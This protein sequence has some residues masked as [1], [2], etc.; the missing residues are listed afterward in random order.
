MMERIKYPKWRFIGYTK[1]TNTLL[2]ND[3]LFN[4]ASNIVKNYDINYFKTYSWGGGPNWKLRVLKKAMNIVGISEDNLSL[5][6]Q[7]GIYFAPLAENWKEI[8]NSRTRI[9]AKKKLKTSEEIWKDFS[10]KVQDRALRKTE[11][12]KFDKENSIN[13]IK[14]LLA[15][16]QINID[17]FS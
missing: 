9:S 13:Y 5:G 7:R 4:L 17:K 3:G 12:K 16:Y 6:I 11:W 14:K 2:F 15:K 1:G 8:L 10:S